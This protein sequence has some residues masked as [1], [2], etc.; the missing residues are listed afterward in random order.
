MI[1]SGDKIYIL[2]QSGDTIVLRASPKFE[3][4]GV[5]SIGNELTNATLAVS[6]G[7]FFIR[8]HHNLWCIGDQQPSRTALQG[9]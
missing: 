4:I 5:N 2:N 7:E 9:S 6:N 3:L 1:L 8:T